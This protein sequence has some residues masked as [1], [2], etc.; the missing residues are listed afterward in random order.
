M[1]RLGSKST[2][3]TAPL[4]LSQMKKDHVKWSHADWDEINALRADSATLCGSF[5][6]LSKR[7]RFS[8]SSHELLRYLKRAARNYFVALSVP[9]STDGMQRVGRDGKAVQPDYLLQRWRGGKG[10]GQFSDCPHVQNAPDIW[11]MNRD[12]RQRELRKWEDALLEETVAELYTTGHRYNT[13][14]SR[15]DRRFKEKDAAV[16][17]RKRIIGCTTTGA[18]M[19]REAIDAA[20]PRVLLVEEAGEI[21]ESHILT[22]LGRHT[23]QLILIGDHKCVYATAGYA[24]FVIL[25]AHRSR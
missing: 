12:D 9:T 4:C 18:A 16:L 13:Y 25:T 24:T 2:P 11:R 21:L 23:K 7:Y 15:I 3:R 17:A 5:D 6:R 20:R 22:A 1:V 10:A 8:H 19:Y 14:Q